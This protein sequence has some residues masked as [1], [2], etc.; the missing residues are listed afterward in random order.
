MPWMR[1][2]ENTT[3]FAS[4]GE[5]SEKTRSP[6][7]VKVNS[8]ASSFCSHDARPGT[9]VDTSEPSKSTR[10]SYSAFAIMLPVGS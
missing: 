2:S 5:P 4:M 3:S 8:V 6:S 7:S 10:V 1:C 9:G